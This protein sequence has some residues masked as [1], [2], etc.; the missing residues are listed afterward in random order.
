MAKIRKISIPISM[1]ALNRLNYDIC[2]S[3]DLLEIIIEESEFDSL[4]KT[5]LFVEINK[6]LD[7]L[8]GDYED[9]LIFSKDFEVLGKI[10]YDFIFINPNNKVLYKLYLIYEIACVLKTGILI[11]FT[12]INLGLHSP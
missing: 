7:V 1:D 8:V 6:K 10:L 12:P 2:E 4:L 9:E 5:G 3:G 11:S